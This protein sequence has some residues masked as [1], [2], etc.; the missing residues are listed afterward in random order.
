MSACQ[1]EQ[2]RCLIVATCF[3]VRCLCVRC[4][5]DRCP[6]CQMRVCQMP[7]CQMPLCQMPLCQMPLCQMPFVSDACVSDALVSDAYVSDAL[8]PLC[9]PRPTPDGL[10]PPDPCK[11]LGC[12]HAAC[13]GLQQVR[14]GVL[15][16]GA[17]LATQPCVWVGGIAGRRG[18]M[19]VKRGCGPRL[20]RVGGEAVDVMQPPVLAAP[21]P[22]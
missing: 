10:D 15:D 9:T 19:R 14:Q 3:C 17:P 22:A 13:V 18:C 8:S 11:G 2:P 12:G 7:L 21:A 20:C 6:L 5:C 4:L 1:Q 16:P